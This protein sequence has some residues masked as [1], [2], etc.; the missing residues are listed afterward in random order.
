MLMLHCICFTLIS[1]M[2]VFSVM[3]ETGRDWVLGLRDLPSKSADDNLQVLKEILEDISDSASSNTD[4][5]LSR[6]NEILVGITRT[7]SDAA[8][9]EK[10]LNQLIEDYRISVLPL[11]KEAEGVLDGEALMKV[12]RLDQH[13]CAL[14]AIVHL[15]ENAVDAQREWENFHFES[16]SAPVLN[17]ACV[18]AGESGGSRFVQAVCKAFCRGGDERN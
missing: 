8:A 5:I 13:I 11:V 1:Q 16:G 4:G 10:K 3:D 2:G 7:M 18:R 14:H 17:P 12:R 6:G 15:Q 9:T